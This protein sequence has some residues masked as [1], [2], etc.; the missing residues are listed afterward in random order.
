M[1]LSLSEENGGSPVFVATEA[2]L[3]SWLDA[4]GWERIFIVDDAVEPRF[5]NRARIMATT[6]DDEWTGLA[7]GNRNL[8]AVNS[9]YWNGVRHHVVQYRRRATEEAGAF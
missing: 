2:C 7:E 9:D 6:G 4:A 5:L 3:V 8:R 1:S